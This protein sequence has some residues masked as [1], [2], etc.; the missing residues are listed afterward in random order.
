MTYQEILCKWG[1]PMLFIESTVLSA[2]TVRQVR[3]SFLVLWDQ[4]T[5]EILALEI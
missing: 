4:M 5:P 2:F 1:V 3:S